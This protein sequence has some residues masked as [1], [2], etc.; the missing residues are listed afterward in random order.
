MHAPP[1]QTMLPD[2]PPAPAVAHD[3]PRSAGPGPDDGASFSI[4]LRVVF[5]LNAIVWLIAQPPWHAANALATGTAI[6]GAA[7]WLVLGLGG[8]R[9]GWRRKL[10]LL[11]ASYYLGMLVARVIY[12]GF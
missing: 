7:M 4:A 8:N 12:E 11:A 10:T 5:V 2:R 6:A 9:P 1:R 3:V